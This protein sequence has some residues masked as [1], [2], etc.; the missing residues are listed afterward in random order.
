[1]IPAQRSGAHDAEPPYAAATLAAVAAGDIDAFDEIWRAHHDQVVRFAYYRLSNRAAAEDIASE[2]FLR[3]INRISTFTGPRAGGMGAWLITIARNLIADHYKSSRVR[4]EF[5]TGEILDADRAVD[6]PEPDVLGRLE[7]AAV[8]D[9][10]TRLNDLQREC[11][12]L[13][14]LRGLTVTQ[15]AEVMGKNEGAVKTLQYRA[16]RTLGRLIP[17]DSADA[18]TGTR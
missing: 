1:M 13:R 10:V 15:T 11:I 8:R 17:T 6:G 16:V 18:D 14:F 5:S 3:A 4:L 2:T 12:E 9:A 7:C